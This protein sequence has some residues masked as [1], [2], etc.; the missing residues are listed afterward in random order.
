MHNILKKNIPKFK[1]TQN[2]LKGYFDALSRDKKNT[3]KDLTCIL[4]DG[5]GKTKKVQIPFD[6]HFNNCILSYFSFVKDQG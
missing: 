3:G 4:T 5:P 2:Q 1:I 6:K